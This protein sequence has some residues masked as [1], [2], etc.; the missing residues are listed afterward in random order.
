MVS[1]LINTIEN[2]P[3]QPRHRLKDQASSQYVGANLWIT[4]RNEEKLQDTAQNCR[5]LGAGEVV[6]LKVTSIFLASCLFEVTPANQPL[7]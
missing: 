4:G 1:H 2:N 5:A 3:D 6:I 7:I